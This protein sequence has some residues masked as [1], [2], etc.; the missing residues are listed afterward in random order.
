[1]GRCV[2][3]VVEQRASRRAWSQA[4]GYADWKSQGWAEDRTGGTVKAGQRVDLVRRLAN[5]MGE[6]P[7]SEIDLVLQQFGAPWSQSWN[8]D[9]DS[10]LLH[11]LGLAKDAVLLELSEYYSDGP[12]ATS[13]SDSVW[14]GELFRLFLSHSS[15]DKEYVSGLK[16]SLAHRGI[17]GFV[18]HED[19]EPTSEWLST[20]RGALD[21][22]DALVAVLTAD[23]TS[24]YWC[25][26]EVGHAIGMRRLIVPLAR[27]TM[28]Y[29]FMSRYQALKCADSPPA[30]VAERVAD[31]LFANPL[32][33]GRMAEA[34]I[35]NLGRSG[36]FASAKSNMSYV[37]QIGNWTPDMM[38]KLEATKKND[39]VSQSFGVPERIEKIIANN[40]APSV[41]DD[42]IPF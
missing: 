10:Y 22:C 25:D 6:L 11:H 12:V 3:E 42:G 26:Q 15:A 20:I 17:Q 21:T 23:F 27:G 41:S 8:G 33:S 24:S 29:G 34:M 35:D 7:Y 30:D 37:E 40:S 39:Q 2:R 5:R 9:P 36:S 38:R 14:T 4:D 28:P 32:T 16:A 31:I 1:M 19:I 18:A 13:Q